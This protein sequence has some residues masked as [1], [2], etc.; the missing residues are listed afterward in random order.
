MASDL[1]FHCLSMFHKKDARLKWVK[2]TKYS[3]VMKYCIGKSFKD[4]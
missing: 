4:L 1:D 3:T 2:D